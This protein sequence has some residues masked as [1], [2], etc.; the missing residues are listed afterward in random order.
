MT[1][2]DM[3]LPVIAP[4]VRAGRGDKVTTPPMGVSPLSPATSWA[5]K[6]SGTILTMTD[7]GTLEDGEPRMAWAWVSTVG[8]GG[9][10]VS[11]P[12]PGDRGDRN[13]L[14]NRNIGGSRP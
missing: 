8:A 4:T 3:S 1:N 2:D 14:I 5:E 11:T 9:S 13:F 7:D 12:A 10:E 6:P